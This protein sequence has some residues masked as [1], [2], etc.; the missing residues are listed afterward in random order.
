MKK[1]ILTALLLSSTSY[2]DVYVKGGVS[3]TPTTDTFIK[4]NQPTWSYNDIAK[5]TKFDDQG[6]GFNLGLGYNVSDSFSVELDLEKDGISLSYGL[7]MNLRLFKYNKLSLFTNFGVGIVMYD[8]DVLSG[9]HTTT[10]T[11]YYDYEI[12]DSGMKISLG[13][14]VEYDITEKYSVYTSLEYTENPEI[15]TSFRNQGGPVIGDLN[16]KVDNNTKMEVGV[17]Y[18]F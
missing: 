2:A 5:T 11:T 17:K 1:L 15:T 8:D 7:G 9:H 4:R 10:Y 3:L 6:I 18:K 14:G 12:K 16:V 13:F